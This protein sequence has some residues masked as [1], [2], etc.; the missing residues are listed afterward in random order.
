[1]K[2][3]TSELPPDVRAQIRAL[4][5]K[6]DSEIDTSDAPEMRDWSNAKRGVFYRAV[7]RR[8][9]PHLNLPP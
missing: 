9:C 3:D 6:P 7:K 1:M 2:R 4:A 5:D 8:G